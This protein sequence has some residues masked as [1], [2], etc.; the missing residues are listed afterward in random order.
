MSWSPTSP[1]GGGSGAGA[2]GAG[3]TGASFLG[4]LL[5]RAARSVF[6]SAMNSTATTNTTATENVTVGRSFFDFGSSNSSTD[7]SSWQVIEYSGRN[8]NNEV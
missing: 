1:S 6:D 2:G 3:G 5:G 8:A 4:G 7:I